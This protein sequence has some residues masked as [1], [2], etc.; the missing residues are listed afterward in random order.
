MT[1]LALDQAATKAVEYVRAGFAIVPIP[2]GRKGPSIK[3]WNQRSRVITA[4][5]DAAK[6]SGNI[7][8]AHAYC[9]PAPTVSIDIDDLDRSAPWLEERGIDLCGLVKAD[10]AVLIISGRPGR[11]KLLY[12]SEVG[13]LRTMNVKQT[14]PDGRSVMVLEFRCAA[15]DGLTVQD[16]LPPSIHPD[17]GRPY[18][19]VGKGDWRALPPLPRALLDVWQQE[20]FGKGQR[21]NSRAAKLTL[22]TVLDD[23]PR[24][25]AILS[26][27]LRHI[28]A[29][30]E[31]PL[32]RDIVWAILSLGWHDR[33][34]LARQWCQTAPERFD[35]CDFRNVVISH[36]PAR[37]PTIGTIFHHARQGGRNG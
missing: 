28:S 37:T 24:Q 14:L 25:R 1:V 17:T 36:D 23:T 9:Q 3:A 20:L 22:S 30:C 29:N 27:Q 12:R 8:L 26:E 18:R 19:W 32:Y 21:D 16:V 33:E 6:L 2:A 4:P 10:D 11:A 34:K 35:E 13:P 7:G 15:Q 31:Y 5:S